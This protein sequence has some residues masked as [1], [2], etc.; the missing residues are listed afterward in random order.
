MFRRRGAVDHRE[1]GLA[2]TIARTTVI[3][4]TATAVS[5]AV[6]ERQAR[7]HQA[8]EPGSAGNQ[9]VAELQEQV[10]QLQGQALHA[11]LSPDPSSGSAGD[12]LISQLSRLGEL[13]Q[14]GILNAAEFEKAKARLLDV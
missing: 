9:S 13:H 14:Q 10:S 8:A 11:Q 4:G 12:D 1:P 2:R 6:A 5:G 7:R 3:S